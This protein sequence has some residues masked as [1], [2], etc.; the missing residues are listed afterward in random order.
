MSAIVA[1]KRFAFM[2]AGV[3]VT[4]FGLALCV[5][6]D[7]G[8]SPLTTLPN[9]LNTIVPGISLGTFTFL[10]HTLF[11]ILTILLLRRDFKPFQ[12]LILP[13]SFVFGFFID[14][15]ELILEPLPVP[16]YFVQFLILVISLFI[17][18]LG[19]S[20]I[21][22]SGVALDA[23]TVFVNSLSLRTGKSYSVLKVITDVTCVA[24]SAAVGL[25]FLHR[26]VGIREGTVIMA[27]F[28]G[29]VVGLYNRLLCRVEPFLAAGGKSSGDG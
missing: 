15:S 4:A 11:F 19:F 13:S 1:V 24:I 10:Q 6:A 7:L 16:N 5:K 25:I 18:G 20:M 12:L 9:V 21:I 29:F 17:V 28:T 2:L 14:L 8:I 3:F 27:V 23:N 26:I 22:N